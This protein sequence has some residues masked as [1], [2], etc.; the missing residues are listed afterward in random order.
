MSPVRNPWGFGRCQVAR[1]STGFPRSSA[2]SADPCAGERAYES[3]Q[4]RQNGGS[5]RRSS[6]SS[7]GRAIA[8]LRQRGSSRW[9]APD[10]DP[11]G[12]RGAP[13]RR[14]KAFGSLPRY[15]DP[16]ADR[17]CFFVP[18]RRGGTAGAVCAPVENGHPS[19]MLPI[20]YSTGIARG[21]EFSAM[22]VQRLD[23]GSEARF[24]RV[25]RA[26][27][28]CPVDRA[29]G[30]R[31]AP[32]SE[33]ADPEC[34]TA[35]PSRLQI[36]GRRDVAAGGPH[37]SAGRPGTARRRLGFRAGGLGSGRHGACKSPLSGFSEGT[38]TTREPRN[39]E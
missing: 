9:P 27:D 25:S 21:S 22:P 3:R 26:L 10:R 8:A 34:R 16:A 18:G 2:G 23:P 30:A 1:V 12:A 39:E 17:G 33:P 15:A 19:D 31:T 37:G 38:R 11:H 29:A 6:A 20:A 24:D 13:F 14:G 36:P 5:F 7:V 35:S 32:G 28:R 4:C